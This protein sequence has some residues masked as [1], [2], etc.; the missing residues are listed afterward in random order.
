MSGTA[1]KV[2]V[3][4]GASSGIGAAAA[5]LALAERGAK[6]VLGARRVEHL[7]SVV[8][9]ITDAGSFADTRATDV[10]H[11]QDLV[12][13]VALAQDRFGRLD[14][15]VSNAGVSPNSPLDDLLGRGLED[16]VD[17]NIKGFLYGAAA[18]LPVFRAQRSGH[19]ITTQSTALLKIVPD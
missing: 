9:R 19:F 15:I 10:R 7:E 13:L 5:L 3:I 14:A 11:R 6:L 17:I 8:T 4:T 16:M 1:D 2:I 12:N 18:A